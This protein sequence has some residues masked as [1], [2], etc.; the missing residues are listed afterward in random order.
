MRLDVA[1]QRRDEMAH[2]SGGT[3]H[4]YES[5]SFFSEKELGGQNYS[6]LNFLFVPT[7]DAEAGTRAAQQRAG[8]WAI[9]A[10]LP[11]GPCPALVLRQLLKEQLRSS[12]GSSLRH[13]THPPLAVNWEDV[14][15]HG[16]V[17]S[18]FAQSMMRARASSNT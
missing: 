8:S 13:H 18:A 4:G 5:F 2:G 6:F 10:G 11:L 16:F 1:S 9:G 3:G 12:A 15:A 17:S 14:P 7:R